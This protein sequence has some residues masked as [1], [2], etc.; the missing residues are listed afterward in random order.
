MQL[1]VVYEL[2]ALGEKQAELAALERLS[3][4]PLALAYLVND[5]EQLAYFVE[6]QYILGMLVG[7]HGR[8]RAQHRRFVWLVVAAA[9]ALDLNHSVGGAIVGVVAV[10]LANERFRRVADALEAANDGRRN[11]IHKLLAFHQ[12]R[13]VHVIAD[14]CFESIKL[15]TANVVVAEDGC[16]SI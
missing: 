5:F 10:K 13:I 1:V 4:Q 6:V 3:P 11:R 2:N 14:Q 15:T 9:A 16:Y 8:R 12:L 7:E